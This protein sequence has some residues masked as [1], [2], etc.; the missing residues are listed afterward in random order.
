MKI[1]HTAHQTAAYIFFNSL[2]WIILKYQHKSSDHSLHIEKILNKFLFYLFSVTENKWFHVIEL[3]VPQ[4][5]N[6]PLTNGHHFF[7]LVTVVVYSKN[8]NNTF[9]WLEF[10][11]LTSMRIKCLVN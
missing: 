7:K 11:A 10:L 9:N 3:M 1:S 2:G 4:L 6:P 5:L 8:K